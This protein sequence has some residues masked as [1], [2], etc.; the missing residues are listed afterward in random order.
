MQHL[1]SL[2]VFFASILGCGDSTSRTSQLD[3]PIE[4]LSFD[5][6]LEAGSRATMRCSTTEQVYE[7]WEAF[8][9]SLVAILETRGTVSSSPSE[10]DFYHSGDWFDK[11]VDGFSIFNTKLLDP[12]LLA[13]LQRCVARHDPG[14]TVEF[15]GIADEIYLLEILVTSEG[16]YAH[17]PN[18]SAAECQDALAQL[19]VSF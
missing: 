17:W 15:C 18:M 5:D 13:E 4:C 19:G 3:M 1:A 12:E 9:K 16:V 14:A 2:A 8:H 7:Q 11:Y 6:Y 10:D